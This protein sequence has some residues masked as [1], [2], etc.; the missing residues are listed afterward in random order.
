LAI[1]E[2]VESIIRQNPYTKNVNNNWGDDLKSIRLEVNQNKAQE[3]GLSSS[4]LEQQLNTLLSGS[5]MTYY[6][7][8]DEYIPVVAE[9]NK[10]ERTQPSDL[11]NLMIQTASNAFVPVG[12]IAKAIFITEPSLKYRRSRVP[13]IT[14]RAD[15]VDGVQGNDIAAKIYP[16]LK[17][18]EKTLPLGYH[19]E[20]GGG[21]ESSQKA[22]APIAALYPVMFLIVL[23]LL[24]LQLNSFKRSLLV[25]ATAPLGMIGVTLSLI[26]LN[27]PFGFVALLGVIA[28]LGIIMR[29]SVILI[30]QIEGDIEKGDTPYDAVKLSVVRRFRPIMLTAAAA[31]LG[32]I[33]LISSAFW[34]PMAV[35]VMGGLFV[36]TLLTL[37]FLP[38]LYAWAFKVTK[39]QEKEVKL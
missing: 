4:D 5:T 9:L 23:T 18:L 33:P 26:A 29:N 14:V 31:I 10:S 24:M 39:P 38:A 25:L 16:K 37:I 11:S 6:L 12:Q 20:I 30:D 32:M 3:I 34:G 7:D 8:K 1:S 21:V 22:S 13:A 36:A 2:Q 19:I 28:L 27:A 15:V 17:K 35:A